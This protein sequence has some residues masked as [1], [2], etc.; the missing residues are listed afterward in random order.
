MILESDQAEE[1][2]LKG[3][4]YKD[5]TLRDSSPQPFSHQGPVSWGTVFHGP[6]VGAGG[7]MVSG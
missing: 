7:G 4:C 6:G 5:K 3:C 1:L 2:G